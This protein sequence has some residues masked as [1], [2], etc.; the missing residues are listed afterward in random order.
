MFRPEVTLESHK[1]HK[2]QV[3]SGFSGNIH[4]T[5]FFLE[6]FMKR[7]AA[8]LLIIFLSLAWSMPALASHRENRN[9]GENGREARRAQKQYQKYSKR[10]AKR[11]RKAMKRYQNAQRKAAKRQQRQLRAHR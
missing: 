3:A 11:Q 4:F 10:Q 8:S 6:T 1:G 2:L 5:G 9:I 7:T